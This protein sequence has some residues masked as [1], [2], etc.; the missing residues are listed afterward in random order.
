MLDFLYLLVLLLLV[1]LNW[2]SLCVCSRRLNLL[3]RVSADAVTTILHRMIE[4]RME[5]R[6]RGEYEHSFLNEFQEVRKVGGQSG[7]LLWRC[8]AVPVTGRAAQAK[9]LISPEN[10][11]SWAV[12]SWAKEEWLKLSILI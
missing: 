1:S 3:E 11:C 7:P 2:V 5:Q 4:E 9:F 6:C 10:A 8:G 12:T